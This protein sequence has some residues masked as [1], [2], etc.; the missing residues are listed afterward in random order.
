MLIY[1][2]HNALERKTSLAKH[3]CKQCEEQEE[4]LPLWMATFADMMTLLFAF[5]VF[6]QYSS[7]TNVKAA[8]KILDFSLQKPRPRRPFRKLKSNVFQVHFHKAF[9]GYWFR[10]INAKRL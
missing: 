4:G 9:E 10:G 1:L 6:V 2:Q 8:K 3:P 5:F 7:K